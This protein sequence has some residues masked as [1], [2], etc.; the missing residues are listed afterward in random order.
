MCVIE[1]MLIILIE[2]GKIMGIIESGDVY[3]NMLDII[4][5]LNVWLYV[6]VNNKE[7]VYVI[8]VYIVLC[9]MMEVECKGDIYK[10][11]ELRLCI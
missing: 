4:Y 7:R 9:E 10:D 2:Y 6:F 5:C 8:D 11:L 3:F 1:F